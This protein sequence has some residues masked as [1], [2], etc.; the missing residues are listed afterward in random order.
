MFM[1]SRVSV[2]EIYPIRDMLYF[3]LADGKVV[4]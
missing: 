1:K 2:Q 3:A 4:F